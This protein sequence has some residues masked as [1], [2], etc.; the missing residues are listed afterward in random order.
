MNLRSINIETI[1]TGE[2]KSG[3]II[4]FHGNLYR[5][6]DNVSRATGERMVWVAPRSIGDGYNIPRPCYGWHAKHIE[7]LDGA[8]PMTSWDYF[9]GNNLA[10]WS[11]A[12]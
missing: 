2:M 3:D 4:V 11:R 12:I 8:A 5:L 10:H 1:H 6:T 9:Q 7:T